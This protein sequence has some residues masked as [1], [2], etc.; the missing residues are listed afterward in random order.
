M[1][2]SPQPTAYWTS[3]VPQCSFARFGDP[4]GVDGVEAGLR[5][6]GYP[7]PGRVSQ[8]VS[9]EPSSRPLQT[10]RLTCFICPGQNGPHEIRL[11]ATLPLPFVGRPDGLEERPTIRRTPNGP[12]PR[13]GRF[14]STYLTPTFRC[15]HISVAEAPG[16]G[17]IVS[18]RMRFSPLNR[19][20]LRRIRSVWSSGSPI[21]ARS[22]RSCLKH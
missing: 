4:A 12:H 21:C 15:R 1:L 22:T 8:R 19:N 18:C 2:S 17:G 6:A 20:P 11:P 14:T 7:P 3:E 10:A 16:W 13:I 5:Q 9:Y